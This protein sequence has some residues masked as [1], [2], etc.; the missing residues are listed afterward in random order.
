MRNKYCKR[1]IFDYDCHL[2]KQTNQ[3]NLAMFVTNESL[4]RNQMQQI[5]KYFKYTQLKFAMLCF[6]NKK[7]F[8]TNSKNIYVV[9][10]YYINYFLLNLSK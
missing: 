6:K 7:Y 10:I 3:F 4:M 5:Y 9:Y 1:D 8:H 2:K